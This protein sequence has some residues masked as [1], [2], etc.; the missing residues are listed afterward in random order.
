[1]YLSFIIR[2]QE[3]NESY[4]GFLKFNNFEAFKVSLV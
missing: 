3:S 4:L 2:K 1:M